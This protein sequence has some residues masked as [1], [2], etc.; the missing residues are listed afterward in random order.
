MAMNS[1]GDLAQNLMLRSYGTRI[2][3]DINTLTRELS[4]GEVADVSGR[5]RGD[6]SHL[7][8][9]DRSL[10]RLSALSAANAEA[11]LMASASQASLATVE[12]TVT[13]LSD[14]LLSV[15]LSNQAVS[16]AH[17][18]V[19]ARGA[20]GTMISSLN[21]SVGGRSLF[22]GVA[23]DQAPL[24]SADTILSG[25]RTALSGLSTPGDIMQAARDWF[26]DPAGFVATVYTGSDQSL[27]PVQVSENT[28]VSLTRR[29]D[30]SA[31]RDALRLASVS[32][33]AEDP[34]LGL[35][36]DTKTALFKQIGVDL[37]GTRDGIVTL[38]AEI[39][40]AEARIEKAAARNG[41]AKSGL[42][43][44]RGEL[45]GADPYETAIRLE[46][47]QYQLE[48]LYTTTVRNSRLSLVNFL[49]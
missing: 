10:R 44:A 47:V 28:Q 48:S 16:H 33:L 35:S 38:Q 3:N 20:L 1:L 23:T 34:A 42:E 18:G 45:V 27:A 24:S 26:D 6:F 31:F 43:R 41:A 2:R 32:A 9:M 36:A 7:A 8:D 21:T 29:A 17:A 39:G 13:D 46:A 19:K 4:T 11:K 37:L 40:D 25:L 12:E 30:D 22:A 49:R 5:L 14:S 15:A